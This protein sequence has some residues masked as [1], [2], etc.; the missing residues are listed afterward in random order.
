MMCTTAIIRRILYRISINFETYLIDCAKTKSQTK[1]Q[2][3]LIAIEHIIPLT[4]FF[5][6]IFIKEEETEK[7]PRTWEWNDSTQ[8]LPGAIPTYRIIAM[9]YALQMKWSFAD[10]CVSVLHTNCSIV[11]LLQQLNHAP[12]SLHTIRMNYLLYYHF[13]CA[14][15]LC[16][17]R[18][19]VEAEFHF[20]VFR[21][22]MKW[23]SRN[24]KRNWVCFFVG[25]GL[26]WLRRRE[27]FRV[28]SM[29]CGS[30]L[31]S[32]RNSLSL[33][34]W[35][36]IVHVMCVCLSFDFIIIACTNA[37][38]FIRAHLESIWLRSTPVFSISHFF[39]FVRCCSSVV[40]YICFTSHFSC[41]LLHKF[42]MY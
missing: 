2:R 16:R 25:F 38:N 26:V 23:K 20:F 35:L 27:N 32:L 12:F 3:H 4:I 42:N 41:N 29:N 15:L 5:Y 37:R 28:H 39:V 10:W 24:R 14:L 33:W 6:W 22:K 31:G 13:L 34:F 11:V 21:V 1:V 17:Y 9:Q 36:F 8:W 30:G 18:W 40:G 7:N 19:A